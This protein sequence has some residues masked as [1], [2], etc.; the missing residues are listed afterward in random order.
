MRSPGGEGTRRLRE[1]GVRLKGGI[2][3]EF[4]NN[5]LERQW[6]DWGV[7]PQEQKPVRTQGNLHRYRRP[8]GGLAASGT[9]LSEQGPGHDHSS[10][11]GSAFLSVRL[12]GGLGDWRRRKLPYGSCCRVQFAHDVRDS[13]EVGRQTRDDLRCGHL[14]HIMDVTAT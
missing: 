12:L 7:R 4:Q 8:W 1:N 11:P 14:Q 2:L 3:N 6:T 13:G 5:E 9:T 10:R